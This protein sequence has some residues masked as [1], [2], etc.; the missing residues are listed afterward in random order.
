MWK[1]EKEIMDNL[2]RIREERYKENK[3]LSTE[4]QM[5]RLNQSVKEVEKKYRIKFKR[6]S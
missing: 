4:E 3:K 2:H 5:K 6:A 1:S